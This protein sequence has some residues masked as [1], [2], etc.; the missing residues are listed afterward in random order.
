MLGL[1][2]S[3]KINTRLLC[4]MAAHKDFVKLL[5]DIEIYVDGIARMQI[6]N[7]NTLVDMA[8]VKI[9]EKYQP[10]GEDTHIRL[11]EAANWGLIIPS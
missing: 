9:T 5:A 11:L 8:R 3:R 1:L 10:G 7:L 4:E 6:Q 2:K